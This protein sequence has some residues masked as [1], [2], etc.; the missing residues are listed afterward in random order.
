MCDCGAKTET[1]SHFFLCC[2]FFANERQ[3]LLDDAYRLDASIKHLNE[4]SLIDVLLYGS[5]RFNDSKNKEILL[6][7]YV[8]KFFSCMS[9][10]ALSP[11][12]PFIL[13]F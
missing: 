10:Y 2:Q 8:Y 4:E 13:L 9:A 1:T 5:D 12:Q 7:F 3:K 6:L 11:M